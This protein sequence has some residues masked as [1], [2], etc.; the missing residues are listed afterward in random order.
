MIDFNKNNDDSKSSS[1]QQESKLPNPPTLPDVVTIKKSSPS[2]A[3]SK[4]LNEE[5]F[6]KR[7][8]QQ[9]AFYKTH[10]SFGRTHRGLAWNQ[11]WRYGYPFAPSDLS[12]RTST[13]CIFEYIVISKD[14]SGS[15]M[16]SKNCCGLATDLIMT[17]K[18]HTV[19]ATVQLSQQNTARSAL[20]HAAR[21]ICGQKTIPLCKCLYYAY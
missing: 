9:R 14:V 11:F 1:E 13:G 17:W 12:T 16:V 10:S 5:A 20:G 4:K 6:R 18:I 7:R 21:A 19:N 3:S 8:R 2:C 15:I